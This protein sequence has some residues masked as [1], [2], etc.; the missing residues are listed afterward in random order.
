MWPIGRTLFLALALGACS[1]AVFD[2]WTPLA[3]VLLAHGVIPVQ[4]E[5][6]AS[7]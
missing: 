7:Q 4:S 3:A 5:G 6:E 1:P 2:E